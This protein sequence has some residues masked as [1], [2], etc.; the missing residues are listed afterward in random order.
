MVAPKA[1]ENIFRFYILPK[2]A[3]KNISNICLFA[4]NGG[5][6]HGGT[7]TTGIT[8]LELSRQSTW[9]VRDL[10]KLGIFTWIRWGETASNRAGGRWV[11][12]DS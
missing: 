8:Q 5:Q 6:L 12:E 7:S 4:K 3:F 2:E 10:Q 1:L 11:A 9:Q